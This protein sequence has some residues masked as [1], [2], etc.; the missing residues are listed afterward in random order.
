M[1]VNNKTNNKSV[2]FNYDDDGDRPTIN[3][4]LRL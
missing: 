4:I 3:T 2:G 1:V